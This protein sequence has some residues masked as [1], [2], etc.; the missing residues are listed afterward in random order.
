M[1]HKISVILTVLNEVKTIKA[2]IENL[3]NQSR[4]PDEIVIV[5]GGSED[6]TIETIQKLSAE[7]QIIKLIVQKNINISQGRN[8]AIANA[9]FP[10]IAA[11]DSGC[12]PEKNW[13]E[14]MMEPIRNDPD[15]DVVKGIVYPDPANLFERIG[16]C[17]LAGHLDQY[18]ASMY[19]LSGRASLYKKEIW[20]RAG[21]YPEWLY[22]GEDTL[23]HRKLQHMGANIQLARNAVVY[24]RPRQTYYKMA[25]MCFLYGR[26][27]GRIGDSISGAG[28]H[29]RNYGILFLLFGAS[30]FFPW[31]F[32]V[33]IA[34]ILYFYFTSTR[35]TVK[36]IQQKI[37]D[38]RVLWMG[39]MI[40][41]IR[42]IATC[43]GLLLGHLEYRY[44]HPLKK[45]LA[46]YMNNSL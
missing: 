23:F 30:L 26:G 12:R 20:E 31:F 14:N 6:G 11:T 40:V 5:D 7:N 4:M 18:D 27:N 3:T 45:K 29:L 13:L 33:F 41:L 35:K 43:L 38:K 37:V 21:G 24:W 39:P 15:I 10:L 36:K 32:L 2:T 16:G 9:R 1:N 8:I 19:P 17:F 25:K 28:Y 34:S 44:R 22:T 46:D 42:N